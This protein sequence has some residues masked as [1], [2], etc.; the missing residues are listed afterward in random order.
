MFEKTKVD[1]DNI[2]RQA[3][4]DDEKPFGLAPP[5]DISKE[6]EWRIE[7]QKEKINLLADEIKAMYDGL[8]DKKV[9]EKYFNCKVSNLHNYVYAAFSG[10]EFFSKENPYSNSSEESNGL[11]KDISGDKIVDGIKKRLKNEES[12]DLESSLSIAGGNLERLKEVFFSIA[13]M[14]GLVEKDFSFTKIPQEMRAAIFWFTFDKDAEVMDVKNDGDSA[15]IKLRTEIDKMHGDRQ[16]F[17]DYKEKTIHLKMIEG[18][19][20]AV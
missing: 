16:E 5:R 6:K 9:L 15:E 11:L 13:K 2:E 14:E 19:W 10:A 20:V 18:E 17:P 3:R 1:G 4:P 7:K 8:A 12:G